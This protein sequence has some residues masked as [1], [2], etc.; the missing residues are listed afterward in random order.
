MT[1]SVLSGARRADVT[2][3]GVPAGA[4][5]QCGNLNLNERV[6]REMSI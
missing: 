4:S 2:G 1:N 5:R 6:I 3:F